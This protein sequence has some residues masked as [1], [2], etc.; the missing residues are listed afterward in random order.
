MFVL[1]LHNIFK[2]EPVPHIKKRFQFEKQLLK[3]PQI[4]AIRTEFKQK[5]IF[6]FFAQTTKV[7]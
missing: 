4:K 1:P 2:Q 6:F 3:Y 7:N 5:L